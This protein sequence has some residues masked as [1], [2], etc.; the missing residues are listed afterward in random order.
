MNGALPVLEA[1]S[2]RDLCRVIWK[3]IPFIFLDH[4]WPCVVEEWLSYFVL[5]LATRCLALSPTGEVCSGCVRV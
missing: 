5:V 1:I 3:L 4:R 2:S